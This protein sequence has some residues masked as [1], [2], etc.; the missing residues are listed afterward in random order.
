MKTNTKIRV[1]DKRI[2]FQFK[3]NKNESALFSFFWIRKVD[4]NEAQTQSKH[5]ESLVDWLA[6]VFYF[7]RIGREICVEIS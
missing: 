6:R 5:F 4:I 3:S 7:D 1:E 2:V